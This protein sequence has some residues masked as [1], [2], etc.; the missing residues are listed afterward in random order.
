MGEISP[1]V[2]CDNQ[3]LDF[4]RGTASNCCVSGLFGQLHISTLCYLRFLRFVLRSTNF[5]E[6]IVLI[7]LTVW[8]VWGYIVDKKDA[9][10]LWRRESSSL[11][12]Q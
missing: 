12:S 8:S 1:V 11:R 4:V 3:V 6:D 10:C 5:T 2:Q 9:C 7:S